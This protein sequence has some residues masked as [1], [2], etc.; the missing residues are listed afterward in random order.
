MD[1]G[2]H[3]LEGNRILR[4]TRPMTDDALLSAE[5]VSFS[6][7]SLQILFDVSIAVPRG[8]RV[9]LL[10]TNG[11]GKSTLLR[12]ISGL[13]SPHAGGKIVFDGR[14]VTG[15]SAEDRV[16]L[17]MAMLCGGKANFGGLTVE[18]NLRLGAYTFISQRDLIDQRVDHAMTV[19]P[20]LRARA[21][22]RA[23]SLSGGEQQM[24]AVGRTLVTRPQLLIIDELSL[25]LAPIVMQEIVS[26]LDQLLEADTTLLIVEQS[27]N[28]AAAITDHAYFLEKGRV[29]FSGATSELQS[30]GDIARSVFLGGAP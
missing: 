25:G 17:G 11:A 18:Q 15:A 6:Y 2:V 5:D 1:E 19:F 29:R 16:R 28:V 30:R 3:V 13:C 23:G 4:A 24:L 10:G 20:A 12:V 27:L 22:A 9:A 8:G 7:G 26:V 21:R 14:D